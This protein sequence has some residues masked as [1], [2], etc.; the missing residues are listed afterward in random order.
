MLALGFAPVLYYSNT[1]QSRSTER[2]ARH[3]AAKHHNPPVT[4]EEAYRS[5]AG[6]LLAIL[7]QGACFVAC[8]A[9]SIGCRFLHTPK[10]PRTTVFF[11]ILLNTRQHL[12]EDPKVE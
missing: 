10:T 12:G 11:K 3:A 9:S 5:I 6:R 4:V 8:L 1:E 7:C 2:I